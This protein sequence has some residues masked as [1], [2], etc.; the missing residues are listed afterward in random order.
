MKND[1]T[2]TFSFDSDDNTLKVQ[3]TNNAVTQYQLDKFFRVV[4]D[5]MLHNEFM[6]DDDGSYLEETFIIDLE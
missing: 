6:N 1:I 4:I 5:K 2:L 3:A